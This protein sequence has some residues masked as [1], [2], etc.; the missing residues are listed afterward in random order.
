MI[1]L[2]FLQ[3]TGENVHDIPAYRF[4]NSYIKNGLNEAGMQWTEIPG[5]DWAAGLIPREND[6]ALDAW[7][8][9]IWE[10]TL[11]YIKENLLDIDLFLCYL[12]PKQ[13]EINAIQEIKK[14]GIPCVNFYC[15]NVRE[16]TRPPAEFKVFDLIWVPE[17]EALPMY[18]RAKVNH[19]HL[20]MPVWIDP[21][22]RTLPENE[23]SSISFIGSKDQLREKFF[24]ELA[25]KGLPLEIR[26]SNWGENSNQ[27]QV[28]A[29]STFKSKLKNQMDLARN[30]G[31]QAFIIHNL[32]RFGSK[33]DYSLP[34]QY[35]FEKPGF[36]DYVKIT[37]ESRI[38]LG[39]NRVPTSTTF[40]STPL[41]YSRLRDLE[42]PM[43]GACY[44]TEHTAGLN[45][46]YDIGKEIETYSNADELLY[47]C[48]ELINSNNKRKEL[49]AMGQKRALRS[50]TVPVSLQQI[51]MRLF[52]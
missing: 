23:N 14:L 13:I 31:L 3:D 49:R 19:I 22:Y 15:D 18:E 44:L 16:F 26:G 30:S 39:I 48:N 51:K 25:G 2:S 37:R 1:L 27:Q 8:G 45:Y 28:A 21:A 35:I 5:A 4:W 50:H 47:K 6:P 17:F 12:Y 24:F 40:D 33:A 38:T 7:K 46:L 32:K 34:G 11:K 29:P 36:D 20:P 10:Q 41:V 42:A 43:L 52:S 9:K